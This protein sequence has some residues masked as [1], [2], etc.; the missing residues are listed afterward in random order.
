MVGLRIDQPELEGKNE[1]IPTILPSFL[2]HQAAL[3][4]EDSLSLGSQFALEGKKT[5]ISTSSSAL[6]SQE[7]TPSNLSLTQVAVDGHFTEHV[8]GLLQR[9]RK[10]W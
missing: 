7:V 5:D 9:R 1:L 2:P 10:S 3:Y 4:Q 8:L 6:V